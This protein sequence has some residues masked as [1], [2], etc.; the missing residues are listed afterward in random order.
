MPTTQRPSQQTLSS[1]HSS[2]TPS[3]KTTRPRTS[4][5]TTA[6]KT[7]T[8]HNQQ[9]ISQTSESSLLQTSSNI[10]HSQFISV[11][12]TSSIDIQST[13]DSNVDNAHTS[14]AIDGSTTR[15]SSSTLKSSDTNESTGT[16]NF[17]IAISVTISVVCL[18]IVVVVV[19]VAMVK[20]SKQ[21]K[22]GLN[23]YQV[24]KSYEE[25]RSS[26]NSDPSSLYNFQIK[27]PLFGQEWSHQQ[28]NHS[29]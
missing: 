29:H 3:A 10:P 17:T 5:P 24:R 14:E 27:R 19:A 18:A 21:R 13:Q 7:S 28:L 11:K 8:S 15:K 16:S 6:A 20:I 1:S 4:T 2:S 26:T 22:G 12:T 25:D 9:E 23:R